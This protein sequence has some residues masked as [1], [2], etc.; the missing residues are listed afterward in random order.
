MVGPTKSS[1]KSQKPQKRGVDFKKYKRKIGRKLPPPKNATNTEIKSKAII[2]PE[3]SVASERTGLVV[4]DRG[5]TLKELLQQ[6]SHR[7]ARV[8]RDAL[9]AIMG[10]ASKH[11]LEIKLHK[12]AMIEKLRERISDEDKGVRETLYQLLKTVIF[13]GCKEDIPGSIISLIMAY[14]FNAMTHL[15]FDIRLMAFN[16]FELVVQHYPSSFLLY[17][18]KVLQNY[19]DILKKKHSYVQDK[20]KLMSALAGLVRCL[21]LLPSVE[22]KASPSYEKVIVVAF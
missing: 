3:Q 19:V 9:N 10:M 22:Q 8:R 12:L 13:P 15:M 2:L 11:P 16:F 1:K 14:I 20:G 18:D 5:M 7:N 17:A 21:S 6:T 4:S